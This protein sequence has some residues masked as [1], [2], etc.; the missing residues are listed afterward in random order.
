MQEFKSMKQFFSENCV[1]DPFIT[2]TAVWPLLT[3]YTRCQHSGR[4]KPT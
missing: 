2:Y 4:N 3:E 1:S